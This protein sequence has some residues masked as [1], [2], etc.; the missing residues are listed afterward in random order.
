M[1]ILSATNRAR[2]KVLGYPVDV[3]DMASALDVIGQSWART[4]FLQVVTLNAEMVVAAQQ[5][6]ELDRI[7]RHAHLIVPDGSGV[8]WAIRLNGQQVD[9]LPGIDLAA[10]AVEKAAQEGRTVAMLGAKPEVLERAKEELCR[11]F[12]GLKVSFVQDG[13]FKPEQEEEIVAALA[14]SKPALVLVALG[15]P[16]QEYF[17]DRWQE[18]FAGSVV[19][20]VGGSFDVW[21]GQVR[22]APVLF[23]RLHLE[24]LYRLIREPW[25]FKR[26]MSALPT[27]FIQVLQDNF[28]RG[29]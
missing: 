26:M 28:K 19:I 27:F 17:I 15:V 29:R 12:S 14:E 25:R 7:V 6:S 9:R 5:D 3:V 13:Y 18:K 24:W 21:A 1:S 4:K 23:Q 11:R 16:R 10:A 8:V 2:Q 22:R 20:G